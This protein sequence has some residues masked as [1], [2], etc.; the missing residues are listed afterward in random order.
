MLSHQDSNLGWLNQN[1]LV[2]DQLPEIAFDKETDSD[3]R[4]EELQEKYYEACRKLPPRC[5]EVFRLVREDRKKYAEVAEL[6]Q[7]SI[8]T[9]DNQMNKAVKILYS[10]LKEH[11]FSAFF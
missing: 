5:L 6:L 3:L 10:E 2:T 7:I 9:V 4:N 11:L 1:E 8:K